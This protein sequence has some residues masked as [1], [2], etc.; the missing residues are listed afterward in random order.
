[1]P[2]SNALLV[3][4]GGGG[5]HEIVEAASI[6]AR[7]RREAYLELGTLPDA[8]AVD[9]IAAA[10]FAV[11]AQPALSTAAGIE[12]VGADQPYADYD[13][14][15]T[16]TAP[17]ETGAAVAVRVRGLTVTEDDLGQVVFGQE[18]R[19]RTLAAEERFQRWLRR[20][21]S[22]ALSGAVE[23]AAPV[24]AG[25]ATAA[26]SPAHSASGSSSSP[27][28]TFLVTGS[29]PG[30]PPQP[31]KTGPLRMPVSRRIGRLDLNAQTGDPN[32]STTVHLL[33]NGTNV[34][35]VVI[36]A[37]GTAGVT[38]G[39]DV[40]YNIGDLLAFELVSAGNEVQELLVSAGGQSN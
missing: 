19:S 40:D 16:V 24:A 15:D 36:A 7:G 32:E 26:P 20:F 37:G 33:R 34:G 18:L 31:G 39:L 5:Y 6:A 12:P 10:L 35:A 17:D 22:G 13:L 8:A 14:G 11:V 30:T 38:L 27:A 3:R 1:M 21:S 25:G 2:V 4:H 9:N 28:P 23:S 29:F